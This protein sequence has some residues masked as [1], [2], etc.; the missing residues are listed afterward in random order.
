M[1]ES[2]HGAHAYHTLSGVDRRGGDATLRTLLLNIGHLSRWRGRLE[3]SG[4]QEL[5]DCA[6]SGLCEPYAVSVI[7]IMP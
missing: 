5:A 3:L 6:A 1:F 4:Q 2:I 7:V